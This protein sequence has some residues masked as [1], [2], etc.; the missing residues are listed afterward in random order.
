M[1]LNRGVLRLAELRG[2]VKNGYFH[3]PSGCAGLDFD[4]ISFRIAL[5]EI[6]VHTAVDNP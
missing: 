3:A 2:Y 5:A 6:A 4:R 1:R